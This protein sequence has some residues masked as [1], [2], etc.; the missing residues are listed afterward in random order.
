MGAPGPSITAREGFKQHRR[1]PA[2]CRGES[3]FRPLHGPFPQC[4]VAE[5]SGRI[6]GLGTTS[7][8]CW[9]AFELKG[10]CWAS[11]ASWPH[12]ARV[13]RYGIGQIDFRQEKYEIAAAHFQ[14]A[15][16]VC[17]PPSQAACSF[18]V[19]TP[20]HGSK[21]TATFPMHTM[22]YCKLL[23]AVVLESNDNTV[24]L[25]KQD[26]LNGCWVEDCM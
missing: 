20:W 25:K 8:V 24:T 23:Q 26:H 14:R 22:I 21:E 3:F 4:T 19:S 7:L 15:L 2:V 5:G 17:R 10:S 1:R 16:E 11:A 6:E 12:Q 9:R 18:H 13:R